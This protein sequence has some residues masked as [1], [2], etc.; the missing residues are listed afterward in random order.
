MKKMKILC[1]AALGLL[2]A[3]CGSQPVEPTYYLLRP[4][5]D[6]QTR[7]M[8]PSSDFALGRIVIAPY[9]DQSGMLLETRSGEIRAARSHLWA[10]PM[11]EAVHS[12]LVQEISRAKG[13]DVFPEKLNPDAAVVEVRIDQLHGTVNGQARLVAYWWLRQNGDVLA[14]Y[15]FSESLT[16]AQDGYGALVNAERALLTQLAEKI[17]A[18]MIVPASS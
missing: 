5:H 9:L 8:S 1:G 7:E 15:Q 6:M 14:A 2:L 4:A 3:A 13:E 10:E 12:Y 18:S 17:A 16:Q 11:Y